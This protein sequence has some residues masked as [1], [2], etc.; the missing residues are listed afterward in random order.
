MEVIEENM[1]Q[2]EMLEKIAELDYS[3]SQLKD[4]NTEMR[5][6]LEFA[7]DD[8]AVL[9]SENSALTKQVKALEK[10]MAEAQQVEAEPCRSFMADDLDANR[11]R[12]NKIQ[13]L[14]KESIIMTEEN[15]MLTAELKDL[16][17]KRDQDKISLSKLSVALQNFELEKEEAQLELQRRDEIIHQ[18]NLQLK[19]LN[20]TVEESANI[21]KDLRLT[22][23]ELRKQ[24]EG[25]RDEAYFDSLTD[26]MRENEGSVIPPPSLA[27]EIWQAS[28]PEVKPFMTYSTELRHEEGEAEE[29]LKPRSVTADFQTKRC[30]DTSKTSVQKTGLFTVCIFILT[31][32]AFLAS[33]SCSGNG[34]FFSINSLW[35]SACLMFHPYCRIHYGALPPI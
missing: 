30:A 25:R 17:Q 23:Q 13:K 26:R 6:W 7:D 8:M 21:M 32:L 5:R 15:K 10:M 33:G 14:E 1:S 34:D 16:Q 3:Q 4:L 35:N 20:E 31:V 29:L 27:E 9:R 28:S 11:C 12:E 18:R 22:N 2:M 19:H 24:I